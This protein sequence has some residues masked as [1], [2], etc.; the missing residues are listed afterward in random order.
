[1]TIRNH[2]Y[3]EYFVGFLGSYNAVRDNLIKTLD[4]QVNEYPDYKVA[5]TG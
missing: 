1:M 2:S 4:A 5:I 3:L